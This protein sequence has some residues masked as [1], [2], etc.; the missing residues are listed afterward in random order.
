MAKNLPTMQ[1]TWVQ[2]LDEEDLREKGM[3]ST[4]IFFPGK[5]HGQKSLAII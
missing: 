4:P 5:S 2:S 3:T 1:G